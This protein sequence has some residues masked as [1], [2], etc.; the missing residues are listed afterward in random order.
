MKSGPS[1]WNYSFLS[2]ISFWLAKERV[3]QKDKKLFFI[4]FIYLFIHS[5]I[6]FCGSNSGNY[7]QFLNKTVNRHQSYSEQ[8]WV[9]R[10]QRCKV[11]IWNMC[12]PLHLSSLVLCYVCYS[13]F[14][15]FFISHSS[16][17]GLDLFTCYF[18]IWN[19]IFKYMSLC[20]PYVCRKNCLNVY[21]NLVSCVTA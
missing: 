16:E 4:Y 10:M 21:R 18:K 15:I 19:E 9:F 8:L 17:C 5:F 20:L 13:F 3:Q 12:A 1:S 11:C 2:T 6:N 7:M 14:C